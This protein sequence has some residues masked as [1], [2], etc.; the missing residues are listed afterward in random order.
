[1]IFSKQINFPC[2]TSTPDDRPLEGFFIIYYR[3][4]NLYALDHEG[5]EILI[6][7][8]DNSHFGDINVFKKT[9]ANDIKNCNILNDTQI[10]YLT[11]SWPDNINDDPNDKIYSII[12]NF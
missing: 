8:R 3:D 7:G 2:Y 12:K 5:I 6:N 4:N 11:G 10:Y 9:L 1:M